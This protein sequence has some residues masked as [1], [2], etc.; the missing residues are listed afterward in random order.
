M[1]QLLNQRIVD[2]TNSLTAKT[3]LT[4]SAAQI[5]S[6]DNGDLSY[7]AI[8]SVLPTLPTFDYY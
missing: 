5:Q 3:Y 2:S 4:K 6:Y 7:Q 8:K 1:I